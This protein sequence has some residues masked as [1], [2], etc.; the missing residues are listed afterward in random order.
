MLIKK[1][2]QLPHLNSTIGEVPGLSNMFEL[3]DT[4]SGLNLVNLGFHQ[5]EAERHTNV[6]KDL[7]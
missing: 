3:I 7:V 4:G 6:V 5:Y 2:Q 1:F